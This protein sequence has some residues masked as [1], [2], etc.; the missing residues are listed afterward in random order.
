MRDC[1]CH[2]D[3]HHVK[4]QV[5]CKSLDCMHRFGRNAPCHLCCSDP[6]SEGFVAATCMKLLQQGCMMS[7]ESLWICLNRS[8]CISEWFQCWETF[9]KPMTGPGF[10]VPQ[11]SH[12]VVM[13]NSHD[14]EKDAW[15]R[16][17]PLLPLPLVLAFARGEICLKFEYF[18]LKCFTVINCNV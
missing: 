8:I 4:P 14:S 7:H 1:N 5:V 6:Q 15:C 12:G 18:K 9:W 13:C 3:P 11:A 2:S 10:F 17:E 16:A